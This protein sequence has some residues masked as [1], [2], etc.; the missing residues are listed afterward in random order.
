MQF[1]YLEIVIY[2]IKWFRKVHQ[3]GSSIPLF[4]QNIFPFFYQRQKY[5]LRTFCNHIVTV[6]KNYQHVSSFVYE[7]SFRKNFDTTGTTTTGLYFFL[8]LLG[9]LFLKTGVT[10]ANFSSLGKFPVST[11]LLNS[12]FKVSEQLFLLIFTIFAGIFLNVCRRF[13]CN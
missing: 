7:Q 10:S 3:H 11:I 5:L 13:F 2:R 9:S 1:R 6:T 4:T 8:I 12:A